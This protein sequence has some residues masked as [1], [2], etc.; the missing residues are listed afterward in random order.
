VK[1]KENGKKARNGQRERNNYEGINRMFVGSA[2]D[3]F[4]SVFHIKMVRVMFALEQVT[5]AQRGNRGITLL[6]L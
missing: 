3:T 4:M 2:K 5:K 1:Y 6:F